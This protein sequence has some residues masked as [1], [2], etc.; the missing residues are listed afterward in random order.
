MLTK[1]SK[2][3]QSPRR[4]MLPKFGKRRLQSNSV[5]KSASSNWILLENCYNVAS[6]SMDGVEL[7]RPLNRLICVAEDTRQQTPGHL[8]VCRVPRKR[9]EFGVPRWFMSVFSF[10][11]AYQ[12]I[13]RILFWP[14]CTRGVAALAAD[15]LRGSTCASVGLADF[16]C[17][18]ATWKDSLKARAAS[19]FIYEIDFRRRHKLCFA[20]RS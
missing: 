18:E 8:R 2:N 10:C 16:S 13:K 4:Q 15:E 7:H 9:L 14:T 5:N 1:F 11:I 6:R 12:K 20:G 17:I 19:C 3:Y